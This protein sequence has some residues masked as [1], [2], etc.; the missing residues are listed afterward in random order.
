M[1][2]WLLLGCDLLGLFNFAGHWRTAITRIMCQLN[3]NAVDFIKQNE[4]Y[5][6]PIMPLPLD[7]ASPMVGKGKGKGT[8]G[9]LSNSPYVDDALQ[10]W[11]TYHDMI[12]WN[13][14][15]NCKQIKTNRNKQIINAIPLLFLGSC[16]DQNA[17]KQQNVAQN[18]YWRC[19]LCHMIAFEKWYVRVFYTKYK[20]NLWLLER[21]HNE[22][23][24][25]LRN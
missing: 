11:K 1:V 22:I 7:T 13:L 23:S 15:R 21:N 9:I 17:G 10:I 25:S 14:S 12:I 4:T 6:P 18:E 24:S 2:C 5:M 3:S 16:V 20:F 19:H 8:F